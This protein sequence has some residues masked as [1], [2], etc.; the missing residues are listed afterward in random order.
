MQHTTPPARRNRLLLPVLA[1]LFLGTLAAMSYVL[2]TWGEVEEA[3]VQQEQ[4]ARA[5]LVTRARLA[6]S[7][8]RRKVAGGALVADPQD[9][10]EVRAMV[11]FCDTATSSDVPALREVALT[12]KNALAAGNAVRALGCLHAVTKDAELVKL[13]DDPRQRV[14]D[15]TILALGESRD[16]SALAW[17]EP[18]VR[19][20][21]P[22]LRVLAIHAVGR[23][24][25]EHARV[26][27]EQVADDSSAAP[28]CGA[29]ARTGLAR[30]MR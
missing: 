18:L 25:G 5:E 27:L 1:V 9:Q 4:H 2:L 30:F 21:D 28:E 15:E 29:F 16:P 7:S 17:L 13:L 3:Y 24:G 23:V 11:E 22:H 10:K 14:R 20:D 8:R 6:K 26:V 12:A 19:S